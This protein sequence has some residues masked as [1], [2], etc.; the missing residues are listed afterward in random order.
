MSYKELLLSG[1]KKIGVWGVGYI[2]LSTLAYYAKNGVA[3]IG[4]DVNKKRIE[5]INK[6]RVDI[7]GFL[8][9]IEFPIGPLV[10][11]GK[12][13]VTGDW[14]RLLADD[15]LVHFIC[16]PTENVNQPT[17]E[18]IIDVFKKLAKLE[19][20]RRP[21]PLVVIESTLIP[22]TTRNILI[23][24]FK[25]NNLVVRKDVELIVA[26]RRDWFVEGNKNLEILDRV[27]GGSSKEAN[28]AGMEILSIVCRKLH[29]APGFVEAEMVKSIENAYRQMDVALANQL[30]AAFPDIDIREVLRLA[31][32][33]WN[34]NTYHPSF[35]TGG[36]CIPLASRYVL[37]G[38]RKPS[39]LTLLS[40]TLK[41]EKKIAKRIVASLKKQHIKKVGILGLSYKGNLKVPT[42][43]PAIEISRYVR[44]N[45]I[46]AQIFDPLY[47]AQEIKKITGLGTFKFPAG[48]DNFEALLLV[49]DHEIFSKP[50]IKKMVPR[51]KN[52]KLILDN[53]GVWQ[54]IKFNPRIKYKLAGSDNWL[55]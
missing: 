42:L 40:E 36:Y 37:S 45:G 2:G 33:K 53:M 5:N 49:C 18:F 38:A 47:T 44:K 27:F 19:K 11:K 22:G 25:K 4:V 52:V 55:E 48:L 34:L 46:A 54:D 31:G 17:N 13:K 15:I 8:D 30:T 35:G 51:L 41:T 50:S 16:V 39:E 23:P 24:I 3:G 14:K 43:S 28:R 9:W 12:I 26:P 7:P 10:K 1:K 29:Q 21:K 20:G 32:T 6:G